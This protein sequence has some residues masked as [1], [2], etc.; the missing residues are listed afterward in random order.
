MLILGTVLE[1][2]SI[3]L[4]TLPLVL[5]LLKQFEIDPVHYAIIVVINIE[6][7][8]LT[9]PVGLNLFVLSGVSKAPLSEVIK[10]ILPFLGLMIILLLG[11]TFIPNLSL[12]LPSL[13]LD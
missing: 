11:V 8:M 6:V 2:L 12:Y 7:A 5:P 4:I 13:L 10:G 9:P 1:G 3:V